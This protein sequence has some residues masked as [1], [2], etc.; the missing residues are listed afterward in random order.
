[1]AA[2]MFSAVD[3]V[4]VFLGWGR[5]AAKTLGFEGWKSLDFLGF[6]RPN[7]AFS[8]VYHGLSLMPFFSRAGTAAAQVHD[9][10]AR[11]GT[12]LV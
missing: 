10:G 1:M 12:D 2:A 6:S 8:M 3:P 11:K 7:P 4:W 9:P 5:L